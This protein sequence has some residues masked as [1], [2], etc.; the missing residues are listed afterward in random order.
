M[1]FEP[2][3]F[4]PL[5]AHLVAPARRD[6]S[7]ARGPTRSQ[8]ES[9]DFRRTARGLWVPV[10]VPLTTDQ[11]IVEA[12]AHLPAYGGVT[13][14][15][16]LH[17]V[18][19]SWFGGGGTV[20][21][22]LPVTLATGGADIR[23]PPGVTKALEHL[24]PGDLSVRDNLSVTTP[25]RSTAFEMRYAD[26]LRQAVVVADMAAY[27]DLVDRRELACHLA[28]LQ[29]RTGIPQAREAHGLM[30]E[31][32]WSPAETLT[33][34][35]WRL[36]ADLPRMR[37]N[38]PVFDRDGRFVATPDLL[39]EEAGM[40]IEYDGEV[41]A[42]PARRARDA[43]RDA[44]L[45]GVGLELLVVGTGDLAERGRLVDRMLAARRRALH[46]APSTRAWTVEPPSWWMPTTAVAQRR[47]LDP[48]ER[49][50]WLGFRLD[51]AA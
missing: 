2:P 13:G 37:C 16:A 35:V 8:I 20:D 1:R 47:A 7:G 41:H 39:D 33:H 5:R 12:A 23:V 40:A 34:L 48:V 24:P 14:W 42:G 51:G 49:R 10:R 30:E 4:H 43:R 3:P 6:P 18:G 27:D 17:W 25:V 38:H 26:S 44:R 19:G 46:Q 21:G 11:R 15:A 31:N 32:S 28:Q 45:R 36:D 22:E 9:G 50:R 29:S